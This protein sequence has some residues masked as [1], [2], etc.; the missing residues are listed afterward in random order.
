MIAIKLFFIV[1]QFIKLSEQTVVKI[2]FFFGIVFLL[3]FIALIK[4]LNFSFHICT[5]L[6]V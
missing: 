4:K 6:F 2:I 5:Y 1:F 3:N